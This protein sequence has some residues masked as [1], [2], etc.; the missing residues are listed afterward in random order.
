MICLTHPK[1]TRLAATLLAGPF[2]LVAASQGYA[3]PQLAG[4]R[5][6]PAEALV[7]AVQGKGDRGTLFRPPK[8][9]KPPSD[10]RV[11]DHRGG[12]Q[13]FVAPRCGHHPRPC[14]GTVRDHRSK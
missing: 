8:T 3:A 14:K 9:I 4:A 5:V 12:E 13:K 10:P 2:V 6:E 11:R 1:L 7:R